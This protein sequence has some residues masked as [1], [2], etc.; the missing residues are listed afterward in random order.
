MRSVPAALIAVFLVVPLFFAALFTV[1]VSTWVLDRGFY[2]AIIDDERLYE[3]RGAPDARIWDEAARATGIT[4]LRDTAVARKIVTPQYLHSQALSVLNQAFDFMNGPAE[5]FDPVVDLS[6]LKKALV[7]MGGARAAAAARIPDSMRLSESPSSHFA[8]A[9]WWGRSGF[10]ALAGLVLANVVL[11]VLA[12][13]TWVAAAFIGGENTKDRLL[14]LGGCL[15]PPSIL[16]FLSGLGT[17]VPLAGG[18]ML[19]GLQSAG[20]ETMGYSAGFVQAVF[21]AARRALGPIATGFLATGGIAMGIAIA[22][23]VI[24]VTMKSQAALP[25]PTRGTT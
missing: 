14:W 17:L 9:R 4:A 1:S 12:C 18:W 16:V 24:A 3:V 13:G 15:L 5:T 21:D 20:L 25:Q 8:P 6:P 23:I 2:T 11:L 19:R 22:L 7:G 10:S